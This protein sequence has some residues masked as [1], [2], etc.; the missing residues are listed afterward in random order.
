VDHPEIAQLA[1]VVAAAGAA[2]LLAGRGRAPVVGGLALLAV[3]AAGLA[4]ST[5]GAE[6]LDTLAS[7][8]GVGA[9][10]LGLAVLIGAAA[11]LVRRP[12]WVPVALLVAAPLRPPITF[13]ASGSLPIGLAEDG[14]LGRLFPLYF[15]LAAAALALAWRALRSD[16]GAARALPRAVS[17]PAAVFI[18]FA[19][20]SLLWADELES[21]VELLAFFTLPFALLLAVLARAPYPEWA[22]RVL[23]RVG[24][25]M[26]AAFAAIG[27]YQ[28]VTHELFFFAPNLEVSNANSDYFR[29]T[30]LFGDP[31][32]YGRHV[33]LGIGVLL[34]LLALRRMHLG[35]GLALL[36]L[37]WTGLLF[38]Y[39][40]SSMVALVAVTL[41]VAA[42]T[43]GKGVRW[44]VGGGIVL[45]LL[46]AAGYLA[47]IE[48]RGES[49]RRETADRSE[50]VEAAARVVREDPVLGVG[51]GGQ[52]AASRRLS[53]SDRS[54]PNFVSHTTPLTVAAELG[55]VGL[56]LYAWLLVGGVRTIAA[57]RRLEPGL[58]LAL[59][60][61][62]LVL[63]VHALFYSG[64]LEDPLTWI[65]LGIGGGY[66]TWPRRDD[67]ARRERGAEPAPAG[68]RA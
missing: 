64:F 62:F 11:V 17:L 57:V 53:D 23:A 52:A 21:G 56:A 67:G 46:L 48:L 41:A 14:Q 5:P 27:L 33:V 47:S 16:V 19:A 1:A 30:S 26:A 6:K 24:V 40:Q 44:I 31:C 65:V 18:A 25:A 36:A 68:A 2:L 38:S 12:A 37:M 66:L 22:P 20:M 45:V 49:L 50:R 4:A 8:K 15:L 10:V 55:L 7:A 59:G 9:A 32:L 39:S 60:G 42:F 13:E 35:L 28:A 29:V 63:F 3:A 34:V 61:A 54:T 51:L 58:G 43:G